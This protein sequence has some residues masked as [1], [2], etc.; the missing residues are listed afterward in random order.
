L[1]TL[2]AQGINE[3]WVEAGPRLGGALLEQGWVDELVIYLAPKLLGDAARGLFRLP[4]WSSL[5]EC[6]DLRIDE[7]RAV[8]DDWRIMARI[9][10]S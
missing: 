5:A 6:V 8:G 2:G 9:K 7:L 10:R 1:S 4:Q 3:V